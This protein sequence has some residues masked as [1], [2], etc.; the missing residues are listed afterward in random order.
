M[1]HIPQTHWQSQSILDA[2][3]SLAISS[4][5]HTSLVFTRPASHAA[6]AAVNSKKNGPGKHLGAKKAGGQKVNPSQIIFKQ[7]GSLWFPG[8]NCGMGRDH[9]IYSKVQ[10]YVRY[11]KDP[12]VHPKRQYIGVVFE[13]T[14][15]LPFPAHLPRRRRLGLEAVEMKTAPPRLT[16]NG[17]IYT[18]EEDSSQLTEVSVPPSTPRVPGPASASKTTFM[19]A[20]QKEGCEPH[21][22]QLRQGYMYRESNWEIGRTAERL[23][24]P[25]VVYNRTDRWKAW[26]IRE[27]KKVQNLARKQASMRRKNK[28]K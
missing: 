8:E 20:S 28:K 14:M 16:E 6:Q 23:K 18:S 24:V 22:V 4:S 1:R 26:R 10:G 2:F 12:G 3:R 11:Y 7:R 21:R 19:I 13:P 27:E 15:R 9:T 25:G 5:H 17:P